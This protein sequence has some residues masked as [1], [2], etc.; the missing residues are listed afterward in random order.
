MQTAAECFDVDTVSTMRDS[1]RRRPARDQLQESLVVLVSE[2]LYLGWNA[3]FVPASAALTSYRRKLQ[4]GDPATA[5]VD[6]LLAVAAFAFGDFA[7]ARRLSRCTVGATRLKS[8]AEPLYATSAH[9]IARRIAA[10]VCFALGDNVRGQRALSRA[11]DPEQRLAAVLSASPI[12]LDQC[13]ETF[14]G[15]AQF[16]NVAAEHARAQRPSHGL[17]PAEFDLLRALPEGHTVHELG[18]HLGKSKHTVARQLESIYVKLNARNRTQ[19][20]HQAREL[21]LLR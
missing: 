4:S 7:E 20:I 2:V 8:K 14:R 16:V 6:S 5:L 21:G 17:T 11:F 15:Y 3:R 19:A 1:L 12:D 10:A 18:Q 13:P 9:V